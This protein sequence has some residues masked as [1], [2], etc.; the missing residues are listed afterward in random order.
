MPVEALT[1]EIID[2]MSTN[3]RR[4]AVG[5]V[6]QESHDFSPIYTTI[7]DFVIER[8][9]EA[10]RNNLQ[11]GS[12]FGGILRRLG[13]SGVDI[14]P[15][16]AARARPG[17]SLTQDAY[18]LL[19]K[20][21][22]DRLNFELPLDGVVF[23]LHGGMTALGV[24]SA[25]GDLMA[26]IRAVVGPRSV[27]AVGLDLHGNPTDELLGAA[28]V[29]TAC[30]EHPH[31]DVVD[32]GDRAARLALA[33]LDGRIKP[34]T[35]MAK[36]PFILRGGYETHEHPLCELHEMAR[37]AIASSPLVMLDVSILNVQPFLDV[38][39][40]GQSFLAITDNAPNPAGD[41]VIK[42]ARECWGRRDEFVDHMLDIDAA[43]E[44]IEANPTL[45]PYV[46]SD[47]RVLAGAPGDSLEVL[48]SLLN[49]GR[50]LC[51][52]IPVTDAA[53][54]RAAT[55]A[56][57]GAHIRLPVGGSMTPF[58]RPLVLDG[59]VVSLS[60]GDFVQRGPYQG[61]QRTTLG[62]TAVIQCGE[63][64]IIATSVA[65][66]T[67]D[68]AAFTSQGVDIGRFDFVVTKSGNH[69]KLNFSGIAEPI[70][71]LT[72]GLSLVQPG[73]LPFR[74]ARAYPDH[75]IAD[76]QIA[77]SYFPAGTSPRRNISLAEG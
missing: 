61:G 34:V 10:L 66:M 42:I 39:G 55:V 59:T 3:Q 60:D 41:L 1:P 7:D 33:T 32:T 74:H 16:L 6:F 9:A 48:R 21:I 27:I 29:V 17:G 14:R 71:A 57:V 72:P 44:T 68:P 11:A 47:Y 52:A 63:N 45:R 56:G 50:P 23:E 49:S 5:Q 26:A 24:G 64:C 77:L 69:F 35:A 40:M 70:V 73:T 15:I 67:Q 19:K 18:R 30:K 22:L 2:A 65:G 37:R 36:I 75:D 28:N 46:L 51:C 20:E 53:A 62:Q 54:V 43:L 13:E 31:R 25:E 76:P 58:L 4:I 8:G 12:T 38:A